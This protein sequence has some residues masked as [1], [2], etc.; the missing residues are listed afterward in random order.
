MDPNPV[1]IARARGAFERE[2]LRLPLAFKGGAQREIWQAAARLEDAEGRAGVGL[3]SQGPLWSDR[4]AFVRLGEDRANEAMFGA[5]AAALR[6]A[7]GRTFARPGELLD[8][9]LPAAWDRARELAESPRLRMTFALNALVPLDCA[10][11]QLVAR[12]NGWTTLEA[13]LTAPEAAA[14][15]AHASRLTAIPLAGYALPVA[16]VDALVDAGARVVK[17][18]IGADPRGDGDPDAML[19]ADRGRLA[20]IHAA[21]RGR[22]LY[23]LDANGRYDTLARIRALL[24]HAGR[25]GALPHVVLLE[26]P[27]PE[28]AEEPVGDL[29]VRVAAD[30]SAHT[31]ED[32]RRRIALGY[33]AIAL[34]PAG[35][36]LSMT[37]RMARAAV[38]AGVPCFVADL[39]VNPILV[40]WNK[41][42]A[43]RLPPLPGLELPAFETNGAQHYARWTDLLGRHPRAGAPW[44]LP[45][46]GGYDLDADWWSC[47]GGILEVPGSYARLVR[48]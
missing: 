18:K 41:Q 1:R 31:D 24:D 2:P 42:I 3:G 38:A 28:E 14:L 9:C 6:A 47:S 33:G 32:V 4:E 23:Y 22:A 27:L 40:E 36:T 16:D 13:A 34:K 45:R 7:E 8:A 25:I 48:G 29:G 35:K 37:L 30:E 17:I 12:A 11:W 39:T 19:D 43:A 26:E 46:D 44:L 20:E 10:A 5:L 15:P 21:V